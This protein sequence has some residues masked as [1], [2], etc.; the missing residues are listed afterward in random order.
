MEKL[1]I[2]SEYI[3]LCDALKFANIVETGGVAKMLILD[4]YVTVNGEVCLQ[5]GKKLYPGDRFAID[6]EEQYEI[7]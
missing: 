6:G 3:R 5:K 4:G 2:N 7:R 1:T